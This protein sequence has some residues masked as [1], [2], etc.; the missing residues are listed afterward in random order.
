MKHFGYGRSLIFT[1][2]SKT[3]LKLLNPLSLLLFF[4][5]CILTV[6]SFLFLSVQ[7][8]QSGIYQGVLLLW[9][10]LSFVICSFFFFFFPPLLPCPVIC[11]T[12]LLCFAH[13]LF[14]GISSSSFQSP[15]QSITLSAHNQTVKTVYARRY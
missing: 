4:G 6:F 10:A 14:Q 5:D 8:H 15:V 9:N 13:S 11:L 2:C 3:V 1:K 7:K 12:N